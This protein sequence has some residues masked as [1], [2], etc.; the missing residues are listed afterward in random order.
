MRQPPKISADRLRA[1][2][3]DYYHLIPATLDFLPLGQDDQAGVYRMV[4]EQG[5]P[6]LLKVK[7]GPLYEP[8]CLVPGYLREQGITSVVAP[9][10]TTSKILWA[11]AADWTV[12]LYPFIT[13]D[14]S[15][16]GM[17]AAQWK[18][19]GAIFRQIHQVIP[20]PLGFDSL[21]KETFDPTDYV[22]WIREYEAQHLQAYGD[23]NAARRDLRSLWRAHQ[24]TIHMLVTSLETL[25]V[26]LQSR[27]LSYVICHADLHPANL[28]RDEAGRVVVIDWDDVMLAPKERD[29]IFVQE[30]PADDTTVSS[31]SS[32]F[33]G[34]GATDIDWPALTYYRYERIVQDV[35][36]YAAFAL[37]RNDVDEE[38]RADAVESFRI[39]LTENGMLAAAEAAASHLRGHSPE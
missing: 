26:M 11:R 27:A 37:F 32:F 19:T 3:R 9:L 16:A 36:A 15:W 34:Y 21:R 1:C 4:G 35:I 8:G 39:N 2:L 10:P 24:S 29:F 6:Y 31:S 28:L 22:R 17:T 38:A 30:A 33:Q 14:T 13:G 12:I 18:E 5:T 7:S 20:P 25:A 23:K